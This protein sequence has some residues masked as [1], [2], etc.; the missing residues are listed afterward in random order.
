MSI[1]RLDDIVIQA[2]QTAGQTS[3]RM[4]PVATGS[5]RKK[6]T[7]IDV[8]ID[9]SVINCLDII[10]QHCPEDALPGEAYTEDQRRWI[11]NAVDGRINYG[12]G[13]ETWATSLAV[14][15]KEEVL[16][17]A[18]YQPTNDILYVFTDRQPACTYDT[19]RMT[20]VE[21]LRTSAIDRLDQAL[22][23]VSS[24]ADI[25][26]APDAIDELISKTNAKRSFGCPSLELGWV[27][28]GKAEIYVTDK[29]RESSWLAGASLVEAS[30]GNIFEHKGWR[31]A[32]SRSI[33]ETL[34]KIL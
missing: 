7:E 1:R 9:H 3:H 26:I 23:L 29:I 14:V 30:G 15:E 2:I 12:H 34:E 32:A 10:K 6:Q 5:V 25:S 8:A 17:S 19:N 18:I 24:T 31:I 20:T 16:A 22:V 11:V 4:Q 13:L 27:A 28:S 33:S 21:V